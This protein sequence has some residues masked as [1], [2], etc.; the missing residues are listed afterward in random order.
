MRRFQSLL[1]LR[2]RR[3]PMALISALPGEV[4]REDQSSPPRVEE[5]QEV[6]VATMILSRYVAI[7]L[8]SLCLSQYADFSFPLSTT[9]NAGQVAHS[10]HILGHASHTTS[11]HMSSLFGLNNWLPLPGKLHPLRFIS[12]RRCAVARVLSQPPTPRPTQLK[13]FQDIHHSHQIQ[14]CLWRSPDQLP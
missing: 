12:S 4:R 11:A 6:L 3:L 9:Q 5:A 13:P 7:F 14:K 10:F 1:A 2:E 8:R